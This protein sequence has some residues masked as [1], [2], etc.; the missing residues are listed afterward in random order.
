VSSEGILKGGGE[1][2]ERYRLPRGRFNLDRFLEA[3]ENHSIMLDRSRKV[4]S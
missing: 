3:R 1:L 2:L 4:P